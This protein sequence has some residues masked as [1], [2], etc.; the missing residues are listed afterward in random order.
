MGRGPGWVPVMRLDNAVAYCVTG[1]FVI[2]MLIVGAQLLNAAG[3]ALADSDKGL[4]GLSDVLEARFG[5][6]IAVLF[7]VGFAATSLSSLLG[8][9]QGMSLFFSDWWYQLR[10]REEGGHEGSAAYR[11]YLAW[12]TFPPMLLLFAD[13]PFLLVIAYGAFGALFMPFLAVTLLI[14]NNSSH[15]PRQARNGPLGNAVLVAATLLFAVLAIQQVV[16]L[17]G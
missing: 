3:I 16:A 2:A 4:L 11:C 6:A 8:V 1:I 15:V 14:L 9:W 17:S 5:R 7:L 12:L 10:G 13:R